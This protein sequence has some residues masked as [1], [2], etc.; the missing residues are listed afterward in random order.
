M[1]ILDQVNQET[2]IIFAEYLGIID[3]G[4]HLAFAVHLVSDKTQVKSLGVGSL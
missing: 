4:M 3:L 1:C 2:G